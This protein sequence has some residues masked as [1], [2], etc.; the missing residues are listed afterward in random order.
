M[1]KKTEPLDAGTGRVKAPT[2][3]RKLRKT[4]DDGRKVEKLFTEA[5][6]FIQEALEIYRV[7]TDGIFEIQPGIFTKSY[8][9]YSG[10]Y[11]LLGDE[12]RR[13]FAIRDTDM[14][15]GLNSDVEY[16]FIKRPLM[17]DSME[18]RTRIPAEEHPELAEQLNRTIKEKQIE[19]TGGMEYIKLIT[20]TVRKKSIEEARKELNDKE[21]RLRTGME[22]NG[23]RISPLT[24][25]ER[26]LLF[27]DFYQRGNGRPYHHRVAD[28][29]GRYKDFANDIAPF[30]FRQ[31][32]DHIQLAE[33][34][35]VR[36]FY[37]AE[38]GLTYEDDLV[39]SILRL[40]AEVMMSVIHTEIPRDALQSRIREISYRIER[41][42]QKELINNNKN[43]LYAQGISFQLEQDEKS[44]KAL[45]A[46]HQEQKAFF[47][48]STIALIADSME[49]LD[50][51]S[52]ELI[53]LGDEKGVRFEVHQNLQ[54][55]GLAT[56]LPHG[57]RFTATMREMITP[58]AFVW[59]PFWSTEIMEYGVWYGNNQI[60]YN[61]I[62]MDRRNMD[63]PHALVFGS[64]G[65]AKSGT[66][67][68][69]IMQI[70]LK[71]MGHVII[72]DPT[73]EY[74]PLANAFDGAYVDV[75]MKS[76]VKINP[77]EIPF[78]HVDSE[79]DFIAGKSALL[80]NIMRNRMEKTCSSGHESIMDT[81]VTNLYKEY[82][83]RKNKKKIQ[84]VLGDLMK[85]VREAPDAK[86]VEYGEDIT[87]DLIN[88]YRNTAEE[89]IMAFAP[90]I[91]GSL[92][93]FAEES[94]LDI[95]DRDL[96]IVGFSDVKGSLYSIAIT[97]FLDYIETVAMNNYARH[98]DTY[99]TIDELH[100]L[101][102]HPLIADH[103]TTRWKTARHAG[104]ILT[105]ILQ[106]ITNVVESSSCR[107]LLTNSSTTIVLKQQASNLRIIKEECGISTAEAKYATGC[108]Q[109]TGIVKFGNS[110]L[111]FDARIPDDLKNGV[112]WE[113]LN[114]DT[115]NKG[116]R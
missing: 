113:I 55:E 112:L 97:I 30:M 31:R 48:S 99:F 4:I 77:L 67:K 5:P 54:R 65:S 115:V 16:T 7:Y 95:W 10:Q 29:R 75:G 63:N 18:E 72:F 32:P 61:P 45:F 110:V 92:N 21:N 36:V 116:S 114:T 46:D 68:L 96:V 89:I 23:S 51:A 38:Y 22:Y 91:S 42:K 111:P 102:K 79:Q 11:F 70:L 103:L 50:R 94:N 44:S 34:N 47:I 73:S 40:P 66:M 19:S 100:E 26:L 14:R 59:H 80:V 71:K 87:E 20:L 98:I 52:T 108:P 62:V 39:H 93:F 88:L 12:E 90:L 6:T 83:G 109:G 57:V 105:G 8:Y 33:N 85:Y 58:A 49:E 86:I 17:T 104:L 25:D 43:M 41:R 107:Q 15:V 28:K 13:E 101:I 2:E 69:E 74:K 64:S 1:K 9:L 53:S 24:T 56:A 37:A 60:T 78:G 3:R 84:P 81:A 82:F 106:D 35:Y 27:R 76:G